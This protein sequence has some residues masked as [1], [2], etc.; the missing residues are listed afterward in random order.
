VAATMVRLESS[1]IPNAIPAGES[2]RSE[3]SG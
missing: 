1:F 2:Q 3:V